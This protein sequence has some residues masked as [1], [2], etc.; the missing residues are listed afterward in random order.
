MARCRIF[1]TGIGRILPMF[2]ML[3]ASRHWGRSAL[4]LCFGPAPG[5]CYAVDNR[6]LHGDCTAP[7]RRHGGGTVYTR[8]RRI[9]ERPNRKGKSEKKNAGILKHSCDI[10][11]SLYLVN[12]CGRMREP[13]GCL[14]SDLWTKSV[15][16]LDNKRIFVID[17]KLIF[18]GK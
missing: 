13:L 16:F 2:S 17:N 7:A 12:R 6:P 9:I 4:C 11:A 15:I 18:Y 8:D 14:R 5:L 3:V 10:W 1:I